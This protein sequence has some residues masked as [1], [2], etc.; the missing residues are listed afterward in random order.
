MEKDLKK[1]NQ[2]IKSDR[3]DSKGS[4]IKNQSDKKV[5]NRKRTFFSR[6]KVCYFC[7]RKIIELSFFSTDILKRYITDAGKI[8]PGKYVGNCPK[9]QRM[10]KKVIKHARMLALMSFCNNN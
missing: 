2:V 1:E 4:F 3:S 9:H 10:V 5:Y 6:K 7:Q 8:I